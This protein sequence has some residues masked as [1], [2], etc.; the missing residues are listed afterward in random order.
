GS[1]RTTR[2]ARLM[3]KSLWRRGREDLPS[4]F[5]ARRRLTGRRYLPPHAHSALTLPGASWPRP[6][7]GAGPMGSLRWALSWL[8]VFAAGLA[9]MLVNWMAGLIVTVEIIS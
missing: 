7:G 1:P 2:A 8:V 5:A 9:P 3:G 4:L 6:V